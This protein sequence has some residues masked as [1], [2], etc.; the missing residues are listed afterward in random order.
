MTDGAASVSTLTLVV[1]VLVRDVEEVTL[2]EEIEGEC[3][4]GL[5]DNEEDGD[6]DTPEW[7][8]D[9]GAGDDD[10]SCRDGSDEEGTAAKMHPACRRTESHMDARWRRMVCRRGK[11]V[12]D[13]EG[14]G[15][16]GRTCSINQC[17]R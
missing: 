16:F 9:E 13:G 6:D 7:V 4:S 8:D 12:L 11:G 10:K 14:E 15:T 1:V 5:W 2:E 17:P 3:D